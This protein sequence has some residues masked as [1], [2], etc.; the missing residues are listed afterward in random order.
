LRDIRYK[1]PTLLLIVAVLA[2][3][4][5]TVMASYTVQNANATVTLSTNTSAKVVELLHVQISNVSVNQYSTNREALNLTLSEWQ[6]LIGPI[7]VEHIISSSSS[8]YNFKFF[9]GPVYNQNG[10]HYANI[11]FTYAV[12]NVTSVTEIAPREY[13][14]IFNPKVFNFNHGV[15]GEVLGQNTTLTIILPP[16]GAITSV[17]PIPDYPS[18]AFVYEYRNVTQISWA[19]A[20]PLSTFSLV[21][22]IRQSLSQEVES[23]FSSIYNKL[24]LYVYLIIA[25]A[26]LLS[27]LYIYRKA[28]R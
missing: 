17:Y 8:V 27:L 19:Y 5:H 25:A 15:S 14:Y 18:S 26:V 2:V 23:F 13:Q 20:E 1:I 16:G 24:G 12:H 3:M 4:S 10:Q 7:L 9:P 22:N 6:Q 11:T 28:V 21:F